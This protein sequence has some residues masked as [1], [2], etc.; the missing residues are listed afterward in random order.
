MTLRLLTEHPKS[1]DRSPTHF[2]FK[3]LRIF[4]TENDSGPTETGWLRK[5]NKV[6]INPS[7]LRPLRGAILE[8]KETEE[9]EDAD[10]SRTQPEWYRRQNLLQI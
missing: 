3:T 5:L 1:L 8:A 9:I 6:R 4:S 7:P 2:C 10:F